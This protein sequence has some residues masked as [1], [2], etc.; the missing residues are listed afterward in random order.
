MPQQPRLI[1]SRFGGPEVALGCKR[2]A[3]DQLRPGSLRE[4]GGGGGVKVA[5][6]FI[7]RMI[8]PTTA[9]A[10]AWCPR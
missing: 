7:C 8:L 6:V 2:L 4:G 3:K 1:Q 9:R 5:D 10:C